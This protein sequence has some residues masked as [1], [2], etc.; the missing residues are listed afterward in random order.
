MKRTSIISILAGAAIC[1]GAQMPREF[2][3]DQKLR[4]AEAVIEN[5][6]V[7]DV[8][9]DSIVD[10]GIIAMLKTL[11]PHSSYTN[12]QETTELTEPLNGKFSGIGIQFNMSTDTVCVVQT[13]SGGPSQRVGILPG[14][15]IISAD[16]SIIAGRKLPNSAIL[17]TLRGEKGSKVRLKVKR[18]DSDDH[19]DCVVT[20]DEIPIHSVDAAY[21]VTPEVG[22]ISLSRFAEESGKEVAEA[23]MKLKKL[24]MQKLILDLEGNGGGYM[25]PAVEIASQLLAN[26]SPVVFTKGR[27]TD[28]Q[29]FNAENRRPLFDGPVVVMVDQYSA[30]ASEI[31]SGALQDN[32]R[33]I[34]VGRRT[35]GKGLVQRPFPFPDGSMIRLTISRYYTPTGRSIQKHYEKGKGEEYYLDMLNRYESGELM[36]IDSIHLDKSHPYKT[37]RS[38]RTVYGGGGIMPDVFVPVDTTYNSKYYRDLVAK[39]AIQ[40]YTFD[41]CDHNR[42]DMLQRYPTED[43]FFAPEGG[44]DVSPEMI[45]ALVAVGEKDGVEPNPEQLDRSLPIIKAVIR[46]LIARDIYENGTYVRA[47]N[48]L[49]PVFIEAL[50]IIT[51]PDRYSS[52]LN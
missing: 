7:E 51:D 39:G 48:S 12:K 17:K 6:Y 36:S 14:D 33:G 19:I 46:G 26:G 24:G 18:G 37:L 21:M 35:F 30:S 11:D 8:N 50:G 5:F 4:Y 3:P 20:R 2:T 43:A 27:R 31:L 10:E 38:G 15:R 42:A 44:F 40:K 52:L 45:S 1:A 41:F 32:D 13:I 23:I 28:P 9:A 49:N 22:Y 29:Y 34:V 47:T 16:D 25:Q